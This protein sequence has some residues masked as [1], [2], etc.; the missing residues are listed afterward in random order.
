MGAAYG[1]WFSIASTVHN[2]SALLPTAPVSGNGSRLARS[3]HEYP[4]SKSPCPLV[5]VEG[6]AEYVAVASRH[7]CLSPYPD[8]RDECPGRLRSV[9]PVRLARRRITA[10]SSSCVADRWLIPPAP[11]P[12]KL[13]RSYCDD[14][15]PGWRSARIRARESCSASTWVSLSWTRRR[16]GTPTPRPFSARSSSR[17]YWF[18]S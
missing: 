18:S 12:P 9:A 8:D 4:A 7:P 6:L 5:R 3:S 1:K 11:S 14:H 10:G 15:R 2:R 17:R 13:R 16:A